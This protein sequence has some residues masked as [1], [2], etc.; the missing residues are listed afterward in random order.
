MKR[1]IPLIFAA[2]ALLSCSLEEPFD[3]AEETPGPQV[4]TAIV[5]ISVQPPNTRSSV[6]VDEQLINDINFLAY[7]DGNLAASLYTEDLSDVVLQ[8]N[9]NYSY[10]LYAI[11]NIGEITPPATEEE[12][13]VAFSHFI[14]GIDD[15]TY[16]LPLS[17]SRTGFNVS[18]NTMS[19]S[20]VMERLVAK[21]SFGI[22]KSVLTGLTVN[23]VRLCQSPVVVYP[24]MDGGSRVD[25][26]TLVAD[27]DYATA[28]DLAAI[29]DGEKIYF[30]T[31]ENC[32]GTLLPDNTDPWAK[33]PDYLNQ[34][35]EWC[36]Y[37][38]A[39]CSFE[40]GNLLSGDVT[41][42]FYLGEDNITNF[43]VV[44]NTDIDVLLTLTTD[45]L[46]EVSW[47]VDS[48]VTIE[49]GYA[50]GMIYD[51]WHDISD[52]YVGEMFLYEVEVAWALADLIGSDPED[53]SLVFVDSDGE[54][55]ALTFDA[56]TNG[57]SDN[58][59]LGVGTCRDISS[60]TLWLADS[61]GNLLATLEG[62][63]YIQKPNIVL[64][65]YSGFNTQDIVESL[66]E[67]PTSYINGYDDIVYVFL[68]DNDG[69]NLNSTNLYGFDL[70]L[71]T[72]ERDPYKESY[73][74][75][76][77]TVSVTLTYGTAQSDEYAV[78]YTLACDN[79][80]SDDYMNRL[81]VDAIFYGYE[82]ISFDIDEL[83]YN[84]S[85]SVS[86]ALW[87]ED[88]EL[89]IVDN[90]WAGYFYGQLSL[91]VDNPSNLP[92]DITY[93]HLI[94]TN[95]DWN[96][97]SRNSHLD[98]VE[99]TLDMD[100]IQY[101]T[102]SFYNDLLPLYG[103][104]CSIHCQRNDSG[105]QYLNEGDLMIYPL[106]DIYTDDLLRAVEYHYGGQESLYNLFDVTMEGNRISSNCLSA[107]DNLE[108]GSRKY[109]II[110]GDD[111]ED[112]GYDNQGIWLY[113][114]NYLDTRNNTTLNSYYNVTPQNLSTLMT[115]YDGSGVYQL[116]VSYNSSTGNLCAY[117]SG[118]NKFGIT[119]DVK[120]SGTV[121][122]YV[123]THPSGTW[124]GGTDNYC[125]TT[126]NKTVTGIT[127]GSSSTAID[128]GAI[129]A[130]MDVIYSNSY[131]DSYNSI[132]SSNSYY[133]HAHPT[134][135]TC[136]VEIKVSSAYGSTL[137]PFKMNFTISSLSYYHAQEGTTYNPSISFTN[138]NFEFT[139]VRY[140]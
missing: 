45:G 105:D 128:G 76:E 27:G 93:W 75:I 61:N 26:Y 119:I 117:S 59:F 38:E 108:D 42:R 36:T 103:R 101:I 12:M 60:G 140:Q 127:V 18:S 100:Q 58:V 11:S 82:A 78:Y 31:L 20:I 133:H 83:N 87:Y 44:R 116:N 34:E 63:V 121:N 109:S 124:F 72:F 102:G 30:Y 135:I 111:P 14:N 136:D 23:S 112:P 91:K 29:N 80:G 120:V 92:L 39:E 19:L 89:T 8:L 131:F 79:D 81:L 130:A 104:D 4:K 46:N 84:I 71:F 6:S 13:K 33:T 41:Y 22:D 21:V 48:N 73:F 17:W 70:D 137:Y 50:R 64:S 113:S 86:Y 37:I 56:L 51:G 16:G 68:T 139:R 77:E 35:S 69:Y 55:D 57:A 15:F 7:L 47:R 9:R 97:I 85:T 122:G 1:I 88:I 32:Q 98:Y 129:K 54:R 24:F 2:L 10:N 5:K 118:G 53:Y 99:S 106:Q 123:Q 90:G 126:F 52:L 25:D 67:P 134:S 65:G 114:R 74:N 107:V 3:H 125:S 43:D 49:D 40:E 66:D 138:D 110:Y 28:E 132:G 95:E 115:R 62:G 94:T 96:A